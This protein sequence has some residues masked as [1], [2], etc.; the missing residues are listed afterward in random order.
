MVCG[1]G[2]VTNRKEKVMEYN[3]RLVAIKKQDMTNYTVMSFKSLDEA[4]SLQKS[5]ID[6]KDA[7][8]PLMY[9]IDPFIPLAPMKQKKS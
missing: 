7:T 2:G 5:M 9:A 4:Q 1:P 8:E 6:G 3:Y